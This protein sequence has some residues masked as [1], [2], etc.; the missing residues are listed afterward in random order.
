MRF[1]TIHLIDQRDNVSPNGVA[2]LEERTARKDGNVYSR[3]ALE[4]RFELPGSFY[5]AIAG[6][7][8]EAPD[9]VH[10][11][12]LED[13]SREGRVALD[14][15]VKLARAGGS[16]DETLPSHEIVETAK[17]VKSRTAKSC[18]FAVTTIDGDTKF[19]VVDVSRKY[20]TGGPVVIRVSLRARTTKVAD[21]GIREDVAVPEDGNLFG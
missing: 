7:M 2:V 8:F 21:I 20:E 10:E 17:Y 1:G 12:T 15:E 18:E 11:A 14:R 9:G 4:A 16:D 3:A 19:L 13:S 5:D 6:I